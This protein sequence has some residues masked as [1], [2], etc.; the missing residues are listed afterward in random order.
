MTLTTYMETLQV[1]MNLLEVTE[2]LGQPISQDELSE[3]H[4]AKRE[5][6]KTEKWRIAVIDSNKFLS[7]HD[8]EEATQELANEE[9]HSISKH[10]E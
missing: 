5:D 4:R 8:Y 9:R 1:C 3:I 7:G 10:K 6:S 2:D